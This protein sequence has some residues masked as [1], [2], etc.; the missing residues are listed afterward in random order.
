MNHK[1]AV[2]GLTE[3]QRSHL[4]GALPE[5]YEL[6]TAE[7]VTDLLAADA[8]CSI[9]DGAQL[10]DNAKCT[11][12][13]YALDLGDRMDETMVW[14]SGAVLPELPSFVHCD[15]FLELIT[16]L[17]SILTQSQT[18]Y[19]TMKMYGAY[20]YIPKHAIEECLEADIDI[21][22]HCKYGEKPDPIIL[23]RL[24]KE[25]TA[26]RE[27][28]GFLDLAGAY[29]LSLWLKKEKIPF[30]VEHETASGLIPYLLGLTHT[31]PLP[32]HT[33]C[34]LCKQVVWHDA[35]DGFDIPPAAC[36]KCGANLI[37]DGHNL[38]WQAYAGYGK[39]PTYGFWLPASLQDKIYGWLDNHWNREAWGT[40]HKDEFRTDVHPFYFIFALDENIIAEDFHRR[41]V[42][43]E[44]KEEL[45][46]LV[47]K[48][49]RHN[50][51]LALPWPKTAAEAIAV[52]NLIRSVWTVDQRVEELLRCGMKVTDLICCQEDVYYYLL[53]H[54]FVDKDAY[55]GVNSVRKGKGL[56]IVTEEM[57]NSRDCWVLTQCAEMRYLPPKAATLERQLFRIRS[58]FAPPEENEGLHTGIDAIDHSIQGMKAGE[59]I[60]VGARP[61]MGK[62]AFAREI[63]CHL[64]TQGKKVIYFDLKKL[65][66][67]ETGILHTSAPRS[68]AEFEAQLREEK[69]DIAILDRFAYLSDYDKTEETSKALFSR[70]KTLAQ[71]LQIPIVVLADLSRAP[72]SR[73][74]PSPIL[75]DISHGKSILPFADTVLLLYRRAYYDPLE[76]RRIA[77]CIVAKSASC[78]GKP[79]FLH[80]DDANLLFTDER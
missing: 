38:V 21:A 29:E 8:V 66:E 77:R 80:W 58:G 42:T 63:Q 69:P 24:R 79:L 11:L 26:L 15:G 10:S 44:Q 71:E 4:A 76:N 2:Y 51:D 16:N 48:E 59:V 54:G 31:N 6:V 30:F 50:G 72:E 46:R 67:T 45:I 9:V 14:L 41:T 55:R 13:T 27:V 74:D 75:E 39:V 7:C 18:R 64:E 33:Y 1:I 68:L 32:P 12:I 3:E 70:I 28:A 47:G 5:G 49:W 62:S 57:R 73:P 37:R 19:E 78:N 43:A 61:T 35:K 25:L 17:E 40:V 23:K 65:V 36:D 22:L 53:D 34:P 60:L 52:A 20:S 56:P